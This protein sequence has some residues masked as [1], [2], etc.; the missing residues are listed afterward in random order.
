MTDN[1]T[2]HYS[3]DF[4]GDVIITVPETMIEDGL[5]GKKLVT[6]TFSELRKFFLEYMRQRS[7]ENIKAMSDHELDAW[8]TLGKENPFPMQTIK[9]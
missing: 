7:I 3:S 6:M 2:F 9:Y 5:S 4:E 1:M 8:A